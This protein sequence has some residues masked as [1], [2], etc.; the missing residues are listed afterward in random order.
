MTYV[1]TIH[2]SVDEAKKTLRD[3]EPDIEEMIRLK[4]RI[5][6]KGYDI[7]AHKYF[8]GQGPNGMGAFPEELEKLVE[9]VKKVSLLGVLVRSMDSGLIDFPHIK[10]DEEEVYLCWKYPETDIEFWHTIGEGFK[11]RKR[12]SEL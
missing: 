12:L 11:G 7:F 5:D 6:E 10:H 1:H 2:F 8:G 4:K 3:I 9:I